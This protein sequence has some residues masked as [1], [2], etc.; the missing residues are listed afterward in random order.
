M[1]LPDIGATRIQ[2][3]NFLWISRHQV[4]YIYIYVSLA[5]ISQFPSFLRNGDKKAL[6]ILITRNWM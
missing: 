6:I 4:I 5:F 2:M 1:S 3:I